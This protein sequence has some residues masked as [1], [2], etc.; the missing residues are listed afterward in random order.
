[1]PGKRCRN[2]PAY[3]NDTQREATKLA[4]KIAGLNVLKIISEP[5]AA[6][7]AFGY[8]TLP[9]KKENILVYDLGACTI[10]LKLFNSLVYSVFF[11]TH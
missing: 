1:M 3:F 4:G 8:T 10:K 6:A 9:D 7:L 2:I 11:S 5:V